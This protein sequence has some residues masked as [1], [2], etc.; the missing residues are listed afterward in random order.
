MRL[1]AN[2]TVDATAPAREMYS[3][4]TM[5]RYASATAAAP[6][7][8]ETNCRKQPVFWKVWRDLPDD[9][10]HGRI[11]DRVFR[12]GWCARQADDSITLSGSHGLCAEDVNRVVVV[13]AA[14]AGYDAIG[15][16]PK[17]HG[18]KRAGDGQ[19]PRPQPTGVELRHQR[20]GAR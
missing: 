16:A 8:I 3:K 14:H 11:E 1:V 15:G 5:Y 19:V 6:N 4:R 20:S 18:R 7:S 13:H 17:K 2:R 12:L 10:Q 9:A